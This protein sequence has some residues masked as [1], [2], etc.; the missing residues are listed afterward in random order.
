LVTIDR[1]NCGGDF[2]RLCGGLKA[3]NLEAAASDVAV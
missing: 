2:K 1:Q 3:A